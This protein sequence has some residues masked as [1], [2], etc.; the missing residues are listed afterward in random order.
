MIGWM[1]EVK[2]LTHDDAMAFYRK[3]YTPG[4]AILVVAGDVTAE[5]VRAL[6]DK[7]FAPL[8]N[9][10]D[11]GARIRTPEPEPLAARRVTMVVARKSRYHAEFP[12]KSGCEP[13]RVAL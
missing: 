9:T 4:N 8:Q 7:H 3:Y 10:A 11:P 5:K 1:S 13:N 6:A 12:G 2:K